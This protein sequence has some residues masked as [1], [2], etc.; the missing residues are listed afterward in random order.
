M[1]FLDINV[2]LSH[3]IGPGAAG[4]INYH[5][6]SA[7]FCQKVVKSQIVVKNYLSKRNTRGLSSVKACAV[8]SITEA[9][10]VV[11]LLSVASQ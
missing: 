4:S 7:F 2:Y 10:C 6:K 8:C 11:R 3:H 5:A 9:S 1:F